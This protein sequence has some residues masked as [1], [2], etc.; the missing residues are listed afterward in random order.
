MQVGK[1][2]MEAVVRRVGG[3]EEELEDETGELVLSAV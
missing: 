1:E 2:I 3:L